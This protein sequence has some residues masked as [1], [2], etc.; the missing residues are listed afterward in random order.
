MNYSYQSIY[1]DFSLWAIIRDSLGIIIQA[2][3]YSL[4]LFLAGVLL[5]GYKPYLVISGSMAPT[6]IENKDIVLVHKLN[7]DEYKVGDMITFHTGST[8]CTHRVFHIVTD[9]EY[10]TYIETRGDAQVFND[11]NAPADPWKLYD[12]DIVGKVQA[13]YKNVGAIYYF[14][15][16]NLVLSISLVLMIW[17]GYLAIQQEAEFVKKPVITD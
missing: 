10:G 11:P 1:K 17:V 4:V 2:I 5:L 9:D 14:I 15:S 12:D 16:E 13:V 8:V 6:L 3:V 7:F